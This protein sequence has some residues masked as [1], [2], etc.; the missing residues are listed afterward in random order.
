MGGAHKEAVPPPAPHLPV[1]AIGFA[2]TAP[3]QPPGRVRAGCVPDVAG[4]QTWAIAL[5]K[6]V[7]SSVPGIEGLAVGCQPSNLAISLPPADDLEFRSRGG[8]A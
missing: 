3:H 4:A 7:G 1:A 2:Y 5:I 6:L 8:A